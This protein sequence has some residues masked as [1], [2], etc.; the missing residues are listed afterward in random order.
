MYVALGIL[1]AVM[2][3][4]LLLLL[5]LALGPAALVILFI[6]ACGVPIFLADLAWTRHKRRS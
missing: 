4:P 6:V 3:V 2:A 1:V 5:G